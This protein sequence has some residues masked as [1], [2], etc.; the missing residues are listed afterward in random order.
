MSTTLWGFKFLDHTLHAG[1]RYC[2]TQYLPGTEVRADGPFTSGTACPSAP[3][4][5]LCVANT[6]RG[7]V[8]GGASLLSSVCV[9]VSYSESDILGYDP[10]KVRVRK[11]TV[12]STLLDVRSLLIRPGADLRN[13]DLRRADLSG[14]DLSGA[15]N[16]REGGHRG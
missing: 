3:G 16:Y 10:N 11:L 5:G 6:W 1:H 14:A 9:L 12:S 8:S 7:A 4:D 2:P 15:L 13:A